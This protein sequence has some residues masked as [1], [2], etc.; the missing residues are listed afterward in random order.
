M[1]RLLLIFFVAFSLLKGFAQ[2]QGNLNSHALG[3]G[4]RISYRVE[5]D[6]DPA[7]NLTVSDA[8]ELDIP[9]V[10]RIKASGKTAEKIVQEIKPILERD[11]Y[12]KATIH[13]S[14]EQVNP[15]GN[16]VKV[17]LTGEVKKP[18]PQEFL[19]NEKMTAS[20]IILKAGGF[21]DFANTRKVKIVRQEATGKT[22][23]FEAD[24]KEVLEGGKLELDP[25][26][27][28]GDLIIV[29]Q[30]LVRF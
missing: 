14:I 16:V 24:L 22:S 28:D 21:A 29:P 18:G 15:N 27:K 17:Y 26:V 19:L 5:E 25:E 13:L 10:G 9:L 1:N 11:F 3:T 8:G 30:K 23:T 4:D 6:G 20:R 2:N 12:Q 7:I